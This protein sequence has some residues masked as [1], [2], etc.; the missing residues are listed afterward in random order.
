MADKRKSKN[1]CLVCKKKFVGW[2]SHALNSVS[3]IVC[4]HKVCRDC[5]PSPGM[6]KETQFSGYNCVILSH[7][8]I[9]GISRHE[10][11]ER[12]DGFR[13]TCTGCIDQLQASFLDKE[14]IAKYFTMEKP[15][16]P[17]KGV[18]LYL[19]CIL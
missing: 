7:Y 15:R 4:E 9:A 16:T 11:E 1:L 19:G 2:R 3:C 14:A 12:G 8:I 17:L 13:F 5:L 6:L 18:Y 10:L